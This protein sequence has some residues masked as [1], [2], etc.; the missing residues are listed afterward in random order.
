MCVAH[1]LRV[2][3]GGPELS[4]VAFDEISDVFKENSRLTDL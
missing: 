2:A 4:G 3:I 1:L